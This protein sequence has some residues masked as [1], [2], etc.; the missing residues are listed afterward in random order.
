MSIA[1]RKVVTTLK[2]ADRLPTNYSRIKDLSYIDNEDLISIEQNAKVLELDECLATLFI[3][4]D[5]LS[6]H[7]LDV[8]QQVHSRG[9]KLGITTAMD[10]MFK[11]MDQ[12]TG[13]QS[14]MEYLKQFSGTFTADVTPTPGS[15]SGFSFNVVLPADSEGG[16][17]K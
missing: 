16:A 8:C 17:G 2:K 3:D 13:A 11:I 4:K 14:C 6:A 12:K 5:Q 10:R 1:E 7:E 15:G 9:R